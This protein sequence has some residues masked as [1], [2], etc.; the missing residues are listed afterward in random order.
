MAGMGHQAFFMH[1]RRQ[2]MVAEQ[3]GG[4]GCAAAAGSDREGVPLGQ[5]KQSRQMAL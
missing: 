5:V 4:A 1:S 3:Q 2:V